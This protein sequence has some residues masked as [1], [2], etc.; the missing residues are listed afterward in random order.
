M[1]FKYAFL[2]AILTVLG[3]VCFMILRPFFSAFAL[4]VVFSIVFYP[5]YFRIRNWIKN[6][7]IASVITV[8]L[9]AALLIGPF[10]F[11]VVV[12]INEVSSLVKHFQ[13]AG[14]QDL[15]SLLTGPDLKRLTGWASKVVHVSEDEMSDAVAREIAKHA[16]QILS[17][18]LRGAG[19]VL[20][21]LTDLLFALILAF[22][23]LKNGLNILKKGR[24]FIPLSDAVKDS[25]GELIKELVVSSVF[26][27]TVV[28]VAQG[29][30]AG[31]A[32][33]FL[34]VST[35]VVWGLV[36]AVAAF[37]PFIGSAL[38]WF[39]LAIYLLIKVSVTKGIILIA[40]GILGISLIDNVLRPFLVKGGEQLSTLAIFFSVIGGMQAFGLVGFV[41]GPLALALLI[42][43]LNI[44][45]KT[46]GGK[47]A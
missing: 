1:R 14:A 32:Y 34:D 7:T 22:F 28:A 4:A 19:N 6:E 42:A 11:L 16:N 43:F 41:I 38:V 24:D 33:F 21:T 15:K 30:L 13:D 23:F 9:I 25:L 39:P 3:V 47:Y 26:G 46:E 8:L 45:D 20:A 29:A 31:V 35:P 18:I 10:S 17:G 44:L 2:I 27:G 37:I 12:F 40:V 36:T 5:V